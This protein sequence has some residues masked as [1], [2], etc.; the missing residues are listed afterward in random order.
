[1]TICK[2]D[3]CCILMDSRISSVETSVAESS[4]GTKNCDLRF[5]SLRF[6]RDVAYLAAPASVTPIVEGTPVNLDRITKRYEQAV[7]V[8][9]R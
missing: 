2:G 1:M 4:R 8:A 6:V 7:K 5:I 3:V 9:H